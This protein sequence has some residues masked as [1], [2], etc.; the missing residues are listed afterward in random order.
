MR[1]IVEDVFYEI[2][3]NFTWTPDTEAWRLKCVNGDYWASEDE[4]KDAYRNGRYY[5]D[6]DGFVE[7]VRSELK[8]QDI[9]S[10]A[11]FCLVPTNDGTLSGHLVCLTEDNRVLD[12][13]QRVVCYPEDCGYTFISMSDFEDGKVWHAI[14]TI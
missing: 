3:D 1:D 10:R 2:L 9:R 13:R 11:V 5:D 7:L 4:I 6:C 12:C 14:K 8:R